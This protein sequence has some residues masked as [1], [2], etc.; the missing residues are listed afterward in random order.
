MRKCLTAVF[1]GSA[2]SIWTLAASVSAAAQ[3][4]EADHAQSAQPDTAAQQAADL[5]R[6]A[7]QQARDLQRTAAQ[8]A[9]DLQRSAAQQARDLQ[10]AQEELDKA[11]RDVARLSAERAERIV[12]DVAAG[13]RSARLRAALGLTTEDTT[14]GARIAAVSPNGPAAQAGLKSGDVIVAVNGSDLTGKDRRAPSAGLLERLQTVQPGDKVVL[15]VLERGKRRSVSVLAR[16]AR[17]W[18][19]GDFDFAFSGPANV[20]GNWKDFDAWSAMFGASRAWRSMQLVALTPAL[21]A[22][23]GTDHGILVVR[24]PNA[25]G[26]RLRDGDVIL[27]IGGRQPKTPEHAMRILASYAPGE[28]LQMTI[29]RQKHRRTLQ[30]ALP[31]RPK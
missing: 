9:R 25:E 17:W 21:G 23:F 6:T 20:P 11:A 5:R 15:D 18:S 27:D 1:L 29:M 26:L 3:G 30:F 12:G 16:R 13:F 14:R 24:A 10:R 7:A 8:E 31:A 2:L 22:Y 4:R 28:T 19:P